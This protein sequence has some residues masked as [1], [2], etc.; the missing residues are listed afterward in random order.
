VVREFV[1]SNG[2]E[3]DFERVFGVDGIWPE[4]PRRRSAR[5]LG[6][7]LQSESKAGRRYRLFDYWRSHEDF[8][9]FRARY[10]QAYERFTGLIASEGLVESETVLGSFYQDD[11]DSDGGM[12]LAP[13]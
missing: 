4:L 8:E 6:S 10:Q 7:K 2:R 1:V 3:T 9:L 5:Y 13:T 11:P 12:D